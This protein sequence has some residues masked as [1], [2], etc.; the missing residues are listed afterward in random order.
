[1]EGDPTEDEIRRLM[2]LRIRRETIRNATHA[3][4]FAARAH[5]FRGGVFT[6]PD[7]ERQILDGFHEEAERIANEA[8]KRITT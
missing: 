7:D 1:M 4:Y 3:A 8:A 6:D 5:S 2:A